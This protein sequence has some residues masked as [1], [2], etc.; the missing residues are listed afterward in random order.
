MGYRL[1]PEG[2]PESPVQCRILL[3]FCRHD[4]VLSNLLLHGQTFVLR[5]L[6]G[7]SEIQTLAVTRI[8]IRTDD[9]PV[10][11]LRHELEGGHRFKVCKFLWSVGEIHTEASGY[12]KILR[13]F[14]FLPLYRCT[15]SEQQSNS[16]S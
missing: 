2:S 12:E 14:G 6:I 15:A 7:P 1:V 13:T 9:L 5:V 8:S 3:H 10:L 11:C 16:E 4:F